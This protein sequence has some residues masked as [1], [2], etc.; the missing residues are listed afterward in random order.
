VFCLS[1]GPNRQYETYFGGCL[2]TTQFGTCRE[3]D[4]FT[5]V[6]QGGTR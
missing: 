3:G 6:I 5:F 1:A 4:D 2:G